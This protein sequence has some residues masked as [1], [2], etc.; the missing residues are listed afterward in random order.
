M[1]KLELLAP[2]GSVEGL[3][4]AVNAGA[5]AIYIGGEKYGARAF[6]DNPDTSALLKGLDYAHLHD[7][8]V[9]LT[10]N[11]LLKESELNDLYAFLKELYEGGLDGVIFQDFGVMKFIRRQFPS[12]PLHASTQLNI[13]DASGCRWLKEQG[14]S[15]VVLARELSLKEIASIHQICDVELEVFIHGALC[16]CYSGQCLLSS[17]LGGRS[18][19]RGRCAQPCRLPY[20]LSVNGE[21][22]SSAAEYLLSPKDLCALD[23]LPQLAEAG[24]TSFKIEGRMKRPEYAAGV[25]EIYR[26]AIDSYQ[27]GEYRIAKEDREQLWNLYSRG[28]NSSGYLQRHNG[29][30][31]MTFAS[32]G[33][34]T[35]EE[36]LFQRIHKDYAEHPI[37][38]SIDG[39]CRLQLN[40]PS[41][42]Y[43]SH[44]GTN[45]RVLGDTPQPAQNQPLT[46]VQVRERLSKTG[47]S[48][49]FMKSLE[50]S[51]EDGLF[52]PVKS[53]NNLRREAVKTLE[54]ALLEKMRR[55]S[56]EEIP[57]PWVSARQ[58]EIGRPPIVSALIT[59]LEQGKEILQ[60]PQIKEIT[61]DSD[62]CFSDFSAYHTL[63]KAF[64][65][66]N[67]QVH[68]ALPFVFRQEVCALY[69]QHQKEL[70]I[71]EL[72]G[73]LV[74]NL[75]S[76]QYLKEILPK[77]RSYCIRSD[78]NLYTFNSLSQAVLAEDGFT[79]MT[80]P[81]ELN[82]TELHRLPFQ[83]N[84]LIVYSRLPLMITAG[85]LKAHK[86]KCEKAVGIL[87]LTDRYKQS[88]PVKNNCT[89]C[90]NVIYNSVPLVL[91]DNEME[92][93]KIPAEVLRLDFHLETRKEV[94][95]I[96]NA[97]FQKAKPSGKFTRGH[98]NRG[99][100]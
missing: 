24:V 60:H 81:V 26:K 25:V 61:F 36:A 77:D 40:E 90:Y 64:T 76:L 34:H 41:S 93:L 16:Y 51:M 69:K 75:E 37:K 92:L 14:C 68:L 18:G 11:T 47:D 91:W 12:L 30:S 49:F 89:F 19:N 15:R 17:L 35:G 88:F 31:M 28:G 62:C 13:T 20:H 52:L 99:V 23:F 98:F 43:L 42:F 5:D 58:P 48:C 3:I 96:L 45:V 79:R 87:T 7:K 71:P 27:A 82:K 84:E 44:K 73:F 94:G 66:E 33:Y 46:E 8:K 63:V 56:V 53:L 97:F 70:F 6:A 10:L 9:Y 74:R 50:L 86:D 39:D 57:L 22:V 80:M 65:E 59:S 29:A 100:T 78:S 95:Q 54:T 38:L 72:S 55:P 2:A 67:R 4:A 1:K 21:K 85:C 83:K 32:P